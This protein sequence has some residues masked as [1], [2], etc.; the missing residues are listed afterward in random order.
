[1]I[2]LH[3]AGGKGC[4]VRKKKAGPAFFPCTIHP[5][6]F[7]SGIVV[8][9]TLPNIP[10]A[11]FRRAMLAGIQASIRPDH[12][13]AAIRHAVVH[14]VSRL[15]SEERAS[16]KSGSLDQGS[17][18]SHFSPDRKISLPRADPIQRGEIASHLLLAGDTVFQVLEEGGNPV[19]IVFV[20]IAADA[21]LDAGFAQHPDRFQDT[22]IVILVVNIPFSKDIITFRAV[23]GNLDPVQLP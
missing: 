17:C 13:A 8:R 1:M 21:D 3:R 14:P 6:E 2:V 4:A 11:A 7:P 16:R 23:H 9:N 5:A 12:H 19:K 22:V 15:L 18:C 20:H 10:E